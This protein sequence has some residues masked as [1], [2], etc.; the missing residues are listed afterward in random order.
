MKAESSSIK[1][2]V[3]SLKESGRLETSH[4]V[5]FGVGYY[6]VCLGWE[7]LWG[8]MGWSLTEAAFI[9]LS[10]PQVGSGS[11]WL[12]E[13][14]ARIPSHTPPTPVAAFLPGERARTAMQM[15]CNETKSYPGTEVGEHLLVPVALGLL[16][17]GSLKLPGSWKP[18]GQDVVPFCF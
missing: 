8:T 7:E 9:H 18:Q 17:P 6:W 3:H 2:T 11:F 15:H 1:A 13:V 12:S 16:A 4:Y 5:A 14:C 10:S